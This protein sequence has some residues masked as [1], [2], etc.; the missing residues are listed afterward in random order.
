MPEK[1]LKLLAAS[2][3]DVPP[4]SAAL[5]DAVAQMGDFSYEPKAKRFTV[6][7]NR[8]RWEAGETGRGQRVRSAIQVGSVLSAK[9]HRLKQNSV[10]AVVS[11]LSITFEEGEAPGGALVFTFSGGG[12]LRLEVEC[13]DVLMA[14]LTEPWRAA[15]RPSHPDKDEDA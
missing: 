5:Q 1:P 10:D 15:G 6:A 2:P 7:F 4:L 13:V 3:E 14:D 11:L 9:G 8:F 12:T